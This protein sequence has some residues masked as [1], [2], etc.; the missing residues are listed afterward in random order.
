MYAS[1]DTETSRYFVF[2][3]AGNILTSDMEVNQNSVGWN[4]APERAIDGNTDG[5]YFQGSVKNKQ[6]VWGN[7]CDYSTTLQSY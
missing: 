5:R 2:T 4:G 1:P 7:N 3:G 6:V